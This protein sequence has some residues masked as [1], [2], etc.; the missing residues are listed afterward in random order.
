V[1]HHLHHHWLRDGEQIAWHGIA[2]RGADNTR[3][4]G[5]I[6]YLTDQRL[7]FKPHILERVTQ[8]PEWQTPLADVRMS[9]G[10]GSWDPHIPV[11]RDVALR[12]RLEVIA[13][14]GSVED[15]F[16]THLGEPLER[17]AHWEGQAP[18]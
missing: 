14:D 7:F 9:L 4:V 6:L 18:S 10:P 3:Q 12:Y 13:A 15:F 2:N 5:G 1:T 17:I 11:I 8:E 16:L